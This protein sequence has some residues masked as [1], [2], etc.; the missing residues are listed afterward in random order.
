MLLFYEVHIGDELKSTAQLSL[1]EFGIFTR[2]RSKY[3][4]SGPMTEQQ[5][6]TW[7]RVS[8]PSEKAALQAVLKTYFKRRRDKF[9]CDSFD[10]VR[11]NIKAKSDK[12]RASAVHRWHSHGAKSPPERTQSGRTATGLLANRATQPTQST[13]PPTTE[14]TT[15][16]ESALAAK[17]RNAAEEMRASGLASTDAGDSLLIALVR[18]GATLAEFKSAAEAAVKQ[19]KGFQWALRRVKGKRE[20]AATTQIRQPVNDVL[21]WHESPDMVQQK[22]EELGIGP[23]VQFHASTG[24]IEDWPSYRRRVLEAANGGQCATR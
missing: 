24:K 23:W 12:A 17:V 22:G 1:L 10:L 4:E 16:K 14:P 18:D 8:S 20:D 13:E 15:Q 7:A 19:G 6:R 9:L 5:M 21:E 3:I 11:K 2:V